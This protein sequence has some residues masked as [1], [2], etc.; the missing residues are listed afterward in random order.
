MIVLQ[1]KLSLNRIQA[2]LQSEELDMT[3]IKRLPHDDKSTQFS[4]QVRSANFSYS[5]EQLPV[6]KDINL[7][8]L[9]GSLVAVVGPVGS[10][11][12]SLCGAILGLLEKLS[13]LVVV[14]GSVAYCSQTAW[15]QNLTVRENILFGMAY[16]EDKYSTVVEACALLPDFEILPAGDAT[17]I[18][19]RG[20]N[21]RYELISFLLLNI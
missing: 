16:D 12:S 10:G 5:K 9:P 17:E 2:F 7:E 14:K 20:I 11:K 18:G 21:L 19:E 13:G 1:S 6:L 15:I 8:L 3:H 4:I